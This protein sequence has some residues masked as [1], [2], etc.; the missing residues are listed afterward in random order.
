MKNLLDKTL[1]F[2][3]QKNKRGDLVIQQTEGRELK[4]TLM[5]ELISNIAATYD[6]EVGM[7]DEGLAI[8][9][10]NEE[11]G[12]IYI[13]LDIKVKPLD[14]DMDTAVMDYSSKQAQKEEAKKKKSEDKAKKAATTTKE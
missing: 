8:A 4:K 1:T 5:Q 12:S 14:Y 9:I 10:P 13:T 11:E 2:K 7:T 3:S 6:V